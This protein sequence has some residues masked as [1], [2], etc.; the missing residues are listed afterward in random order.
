[1]TR[2]K[3]Q[4]YYPNDIN[5]LAHFMVNEDINIYICVVKVSE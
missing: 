2:I 5:F 3:R 4:L 1:M